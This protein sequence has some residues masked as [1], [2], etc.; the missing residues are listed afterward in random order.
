MPAQVPTSSQATDQEMKT[1]AKDETEA[2]RKSSCTAT[3]PPLVNADDSRCSEDVASHQV[4]DH[5][6]KSS[7]ADDTS[8]K[9]SAS[10]IGDDSLS[11]LLSNQSSSVESIL[12]TDDE[13][14]ETLARMQRKFAVRDKVL[15]RLSRGIDNQKYIKFLRENEEAA[16]REAMRRVKRSGQQRKKERQKIRQEAGS[17][18]HEIVI[19]PKRSNTRD[20]TLPDEVDNTETHKETH[21]DA[22]PPVSSFQDIFHGLKRIA[23]FDLYYGVPGHV[24]ILLFC[25]AH[26]SIYEGLYTATAEIT[27]KVKNQ[28]LVYGVVLLVGLTLSRASG[29]LWSWINEEKRECVRFDMHNRLRLGTYDARLLRWFRRHTHFKIAVNT[30][31][32]YLCFIGVAYWLNVMLYHCCDVRSRLLETLPSTIAES[33][34]EVLNLLEYELPDHIQKTGERKK[35]CVELQIDLKDYEGHEC[36]DDGWGTGDFSALDDAYIFKYLSQS[37]YLTLLGVYDTALVTTAGTLIFY[38]INAG[39]SVYIIYKA[40]VP[41][42]EI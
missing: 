4:S 26:I 19:S 34:S 28:N 30:L 27:K 15:K 31:S 21:A 29:Y 16:R 38:T 41:F 9:S 2:H 36:M 40:G 23:L 20:L 7:D 35:S 42:W 33:T 6:R 22:E 8:V 39:L 5:D 12:S 10:S 24:V 11:T 32:L 13:R 17:P 14:V 18:P 3:E 37:S 25:V 1:T